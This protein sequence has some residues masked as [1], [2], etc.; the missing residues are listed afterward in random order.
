MV[1][2]AELV[3]ESGNVWLLIRMPDGSLLARI[4]GRAERVLGPAAACLVADHGFKVGR[5]SERDP[6]RYV[7]QVDD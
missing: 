6:G 3:N 7:Y 1:T 2:V 5:W 4:E